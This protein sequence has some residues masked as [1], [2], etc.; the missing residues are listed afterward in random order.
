MESDVLRAPLQMVR[1]VGIGRWLQQ[2]PLPPKQSVD[3]TKPQWLQKAIKFA[4]LVPNAVAISLG[5]KGR[6]QL[7]VPY[8][9]LPSLAPYRPDGN[10]LDDGVVGFGA[11][12]WILHGMWLEHTAESESLSMRHK[13]ELKEDKEGDAWFQKSC[14]SDRF[15]VSCT[16]GEERPQATVPLQRP[17]R[18]Q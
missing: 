7:S 11:T 10:A 12:M 16:K 15:A 3:P 2:S 13:A 14:K 9:D 1:E 18:P 5:D 8:A 4:M 6:V 17:C